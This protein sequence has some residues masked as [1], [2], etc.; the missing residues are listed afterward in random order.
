MV[1]V[2]WHPSHATCGRTGRAWARVIAGV[3]WQVAQVRPASWCCS[4]QPVQAT[5]ESTG[6]MVTDGAWQASQRSPA[7]RRCGNATARW[8]RGRRAAATATRTSRLSGSRDGSWHW[9]HPPRL[10]STWWQIRQPRGGSK[11]SFSPVRLR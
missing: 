9:A 2:G 3:L 6:A 11:V 1:A 5:A 7:W 4:W 10:T 8:C